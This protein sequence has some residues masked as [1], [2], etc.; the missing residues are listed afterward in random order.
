MEVHHG[1][2]VITCLGAANRDP[3]MFPEPDRLILGRPNANRHLAFSSGAHYCLGASLAR[4]E[5][6]IAITRLIR[7]FPNLRLV[8]EP[9]WRDR[10]TIRGVDRLQLAF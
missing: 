8:G 7:R 5:A 2:V 4:M 9:R 6:E 10:L 3:E 1:E